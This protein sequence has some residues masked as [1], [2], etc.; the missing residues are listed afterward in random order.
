M[1]KVYVL[2]PALILSMGAMAQVAKSKPVVA[3]DETP[4]VSHTELKAMRPMEFGKAAGDVIFSDDFSTGLSNWTRTP[5]TMDTIW[6]HDLDGPNGTFSNVSQVIQSTTAANGFAMFDADFSNPASPYAD[7]AGKFTS[8]VIDMSGIANAII[9]FQHT[10]RTCCSNTFF[11]KVEVSTDN[12]ATFA[13]YDATVY[14]VS[15]N[16]AAPTTLTKINISGFLDTASNLNNFQMRFFFD[17]VTGT[18]H[19]FW[20]ID[21]V[22]LFE[23]WTNDLTM[24]STTFYSGVEQIG[25]Y[26]IPSSQ[27]APINFEARLVNNGAAASNN[28]LLT[29]N[30][31]NGG[32]S[33]VSPTKNI[34]SE[35]VDT[36][37]TATFTPATT[38]QSYTATYALTAQAADQNAVDNG[39]SQTF[40]ITESL[41]SVDNGLNFGQITNFAS[42][43]GQPL[44]IGNLMEIFA[45]TTFDK[46]QIALS[47]SNNNLNQLFFGEVF[48]YNTATQDF[49]FAGNTEEITVSAA[50]NGQMVTLNMLAPVTFNAGDLILVLACHNGNPNGDLG[51]RSG[52]VVRQGTVLGYL[53]DGS[54][55]N[56]ANPRAVRVR[57]IEQ[58]SDASVKELSGVTMGQL[59]PNPTSGNTA[60]NFNMNAASNVVIEVK[61]MNG[62]AIASYDLG[63][64][65]AG[66]HTFNVDTK[67]LN[68]GVYFVSVNTNAGTSTKKLIKK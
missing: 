3:S 39:A 59:F 51:F 34:P 9:S 46:M 41:Y 16:V 68:S 33:V 32:G 25:Y 42:N 10:Y 47:T 61:D 64:Q 26:N 57:M 38:V 49:D 13:T 30:L 65:T 18:S 37:I 7:R 62:R 52:Q 54:L 66:G 60:V 11:P 67:E 15:V 14:G 50:N 22:N 2:A 55:V 21:D 31:N 40:N 58:P 4:G 35:A 28:A 48:I 8:P 17:G 23:S 6:K 27:V 63:N 29:V 36:L 43:S 20:Q 19:Y 44:K 45:P 56:L 12:F 5:N 53:A 24:N 1:K